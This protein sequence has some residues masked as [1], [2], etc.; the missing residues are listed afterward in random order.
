MVGFSRGAM[1]TLQSIA[2]GAP[3]RAAVVVGAPT[4]LSPSRQENAGVRELAR[5]RAT[6]R[7]TC[8]REVT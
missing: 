2:R 4:D 6:P 3:V 7:K 8:G 1:M 5:R